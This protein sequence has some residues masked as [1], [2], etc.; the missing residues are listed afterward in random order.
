MK[1]PFP[2]LADGWREDRLQLQTETRKISHRLR[3]HLASK[4]SRDKAWSNP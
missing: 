2:R 4:P 1:A 3:F